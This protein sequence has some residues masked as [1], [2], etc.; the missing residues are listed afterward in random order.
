MTQGILPIAPSPLVGPALLA[1][2]LEPPPGRPTHIPRDGLM[3]RIDATGSARLLLIAAP[4]GWGKTTTLAAWSRRTAES[5]DVAWLSLDPADDDPARFWAYVA[6]ALSRAAA[7]MSLE[8]PIAEGAVPQ[9]ALARLLNTLGERADPVVLVLDDYQVVTSSDIHEQ[10]S[11]F[12][13][14]LPPAL[15]V[16]V[17]T[18]SEPPLPLGRLRG[19]GDLAELRSADLGFEHAEAESLL[20]GRLALDLRRDEIERLWERTEGWAAALYLA[21]LSL[22]GRDDRTA[23]VEGFAGDDRHIVDYLGGEVMA[24]LPS[25]LRTFL[26]RTS[27]L[28]RLS[29]PLCDAVLET[30][31]SQALLDQLERSNLFIA[32]LDS[33]RGWYRYHQLFR[34][35]LHG[36]L[37]AT[38]PDQEDALHRRASGWLRE[39]GET[40]PAIAHALAAGDA[41]DAADLVARTWLEFVNHGRVSTVSSWLAALPE[42]RLRSDPRLALAVAWTDLMLGRLDAVETWLN[43][44]EGC[45]GPIPPLPG[46]TSIPS[47]IAMARTHLHRLRGEMDAAVRWGRRAVELETGDG[48]GRARA[49]DALGSALYW[50]G[51]TEAGEHLEL[52]IRTAARHDQQ[53]VLA[54]AR[55]HLSAVLV[56]RGEAIAGVRMAREGLDG[57]CVHCLADAPQT[58]VAR[59]TLGAALAVEHQPDAADDQLT[60][61]LRLARGGGGPILTGAAL[62]ALARFR[63]DRGFEAEARSLLRE[64]RTQMRACPDP[65]VVAT[66]LMHADE[67]VGHGGP[68]LHETRS[69]PKGVAREDL[70]SRELAVLAL[71]PSLLTQREIGER[72]HLS[73]NTVKTHI[74]GL[75]RKLGVST[76]GQAVERAAELGIRRPAAR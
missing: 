59:M 26:R 61:A 6:T 44:A 3:D 28:E 73:R 2:K 25:R 38:E 5:A 55:G 15:R 41:A 34:E 16:I 53:L 19:R 47:S 37:R 36:E 9:E 39:H 48:P 1:T 45:A 18:R 22:E 49:H 8:V 64:A 42:P 50:S 17:A 4:A 24:A 74:R 66:L 75:Y 63:S 20:N 21:G 67:A 54:N 40:S 13:D 11:W 52:A 35:I 60:R 32:P 12:I 23:F 31:G 51:A 58:A 10:V 62:I 43:A 14:H 46:A 7:P 70:T 68:A 27:V 56:E 72:L 69:V 65:G 30:E 57:A 76:R 33:H 29:A 71:L